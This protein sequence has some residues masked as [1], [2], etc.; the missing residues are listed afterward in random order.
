MIKYRYQ[1]LLFLWIAFFLNQADRQI[2]SI[3]MPLIKKDLDLTDSQLGLISSLLVWTFGLMVPI[4]GIIGDRFSRKQVIYLST[5]FWSTATFF[6]GACST[7]FQFLIVRGIATGGGEAFYAPSANSLISDEF[8]DKKSVA[9]SIHQSAVYFGIILSGL[10]V[11]FLSDRYGWRSS[12]FVFGIAGVVVSILM[13]TRI[14]STPPV[15]T[16][17]KGEL[18]KNALSVFRTPTV[19]LL[20]S[21]FAC[22]VFVNVGYLAW[23]PSL[24]VENFNLSLSTAGFASMFYHHI[25]AF[26]GVVLGGYVAD[27]LS[28]SGSVYRLIVQAVAL[29]CGAPFIFLLGKANSV[30]SVNTFLFLFGLFRGAYDSNIFAAIY[31]VVP[32]SVKASASGAVLTFAFLVGAFSPFLLGILKPMMGL[33]EA[34]SYL[35]ISYFLGAVFIFIAIIFFYKKDRVATLPIVQIV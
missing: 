4:A 13:A 22:M 33:G 14:K 21:A 27:R 29:L 28:R 19:V 15:S 8:S 35:W 9:L 20:T 30:E 34:F 5:L 26:V 17:N 11:G 10:L 23:M 25:G 18:M 16:V 32:Q 6:T 3:A 7:F 12:F 24:M 2:F 31:D 1:L